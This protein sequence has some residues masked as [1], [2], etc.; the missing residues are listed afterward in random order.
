MALGLLGMLY[1]MGGFGSPEI[2]NFRD[3]CRRRELRES[4]RI[5]P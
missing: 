5:L 4:L 3:Q 2:K 1:F